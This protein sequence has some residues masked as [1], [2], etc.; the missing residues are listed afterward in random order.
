MCCYPERWVYYAELGNTEKR[1]FLSYDNV[2]HLENGRILNIELVPFWIVME[3]LRIED[4]DIKDHIS[5]MD[6]LEEVEYNQSYD[7]PVYSKLPKDIKGRA[8]KV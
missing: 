8:I 4:K 1:H 3:K 6:W 5:S 7:L 2:R